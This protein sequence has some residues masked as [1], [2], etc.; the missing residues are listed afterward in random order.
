MVWGGISWYNKTGLIF[1]RGNLTAERYVEEELGEP[2][3][4]TQSDD[5][6]IVEVEHDTDSEQSADE[7]EEDIAS[8]PLYTGKDGES[9]WNMHCPPRNRRIVEH[10]LVRFLPGAKLAAINVSTKL[11]CWKLFF[12]DAIID[13][14][15]NFAH[16]SRPI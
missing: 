16:W 3:D 10:N 12:P 2:L 7:V 15:V 11:E 6:D 14:I 8:G 1:I 9:R 4:S 13:D 5:E